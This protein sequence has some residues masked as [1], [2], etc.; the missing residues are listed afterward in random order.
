MYLEKVLTA[1]SVCNRKVTIEVVWEPDL[2]SG[3][4]KKGEKVWRP[5]QHYFTRALRMSI[6]LE[7]CDIGGLKNEQIEA[8]LAFHWLHLNPT[9][10]I[11]AFHANS[12]IAHGNA[13]RVSR[14][15]PSSLDFAS[16]RLGLAPR[17]Q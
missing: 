3:R 5:L 14:P 12:S 17:L 13:A 7:T 16:E 8:I 10:A 15:K 4:E 11:L 9:E 2:F 6:S 1:V